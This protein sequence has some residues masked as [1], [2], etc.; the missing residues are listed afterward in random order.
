MTEHTP[1]NDAT[2]HDAVKVLTGVGNTA[3]HR[4]ARQAT[5]A[6]VSVAL[7]LI[8]VKIGAWAETGSVAILSSLVDSL[9][10]AFASIVTLF[11]V[12]HSLVPADEEHRFG[13]G[14]A[15]PLAA[16]AQ[17]AFIA[18]SSVLLLVQAGER[19]LHPK[20]IESTNIGVSV[21]VFSIVA[22]L[23]LVTFQTYVIRKSESLAI[24]ADSIHY[25]GDL[26]ANVGVIGA[27]LLTDMMGWVY[28]DPLFGFGIA[29]FLIW[30]AKSVA[31]EAYD[32]LMDRELPEEE[33]NRIKEIAIWH[34][35]VLSIHD[36]RTRRSGPYRFVQMHL[37]FN[38]QQTLN[39]TH[40]VAD[41]V[42][43]QI[44]AEFPGAQVIVH[45][46]PGTPHEHTDHAH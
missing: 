16:L 19:L 40:A 39:R 8:I 5:Y 23:I 35:D 11:A 32:M 31:M 44:M 45:Q 14:A 34:S 6:S 22:T 30:S 18:G 28:A 17:S 24:K 2:D 21:M 29:I 36:L 1:S 42:E 12:R 15:E 7:I 25:K 13:H 9:L 26:I 43:Q 10:D 20:P 4:L 38:G 41:A 33:R 27:I 3:G 46:D 37:E